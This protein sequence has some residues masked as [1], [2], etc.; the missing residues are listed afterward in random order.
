MITD[1]N[2]NRGQICAANIMRTNEYLFADSVFLRDFI[3]AVPQPVFVKDDEHRYVI[4]NEAMCELMG[5]SRD[6]LLGRKDKD[7]LPAHLVSTYIEG[8]RLVLETGNDNENEELFV[9]A[10]GRQRVLI[11][12][13]K[14]LQGANAARFV[15][16]CVNDVTDFRKTESNFHRTTIARIEAERALEDQ[17]RRFDAALNNFPHGLCMFDEQKR[18]IICNSAYAKMYALPANLTLVGTPLQQIVD[19]RLS[20]GNAPTDRSTYFDI[21]DL[22]KA[23]GRF[24]DTAA[25]LQDGRTIKITVNPM[26]AGG[27]VAT[28]EDITETVRAE[29]RAHELAQEASAEQEKL[30]AALSNMPNG[31]CMFDANHCLVI[32]NARYAEMYNLPPHLLKPGTP[33]QSIVD[34]RHGIGNGPKDFPDYVTQLL[35]DQKWSG[36]IAA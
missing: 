16:G 32:S 35:T 11:T 6:E 27:Y 8:D 36:L 17:N 31:L 29:Q 2:C 24:A 34:Y 15:I 10:K 22:T 3:D 7:F 5:H 28:H 19:H 13:K 20:I 23:S 21:I 12:R 14:R 1:K 33:L 26:I 25:K 9:D 30:A 4:V 18:L